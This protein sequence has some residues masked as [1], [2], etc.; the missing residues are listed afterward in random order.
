MDDGPKAQEE[1]ELAEQDNR[2]I[3][4]RNLGYHILSWHSKCPG[5]PTHFIRKR[6]TTLCSTVTVIFT[7][8]LLFLLNAQG[9]KHAW[10]EAINI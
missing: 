1:N 6:L 4:K 7:F 3:T 5:N 2:R 8:V 9:G 10:M